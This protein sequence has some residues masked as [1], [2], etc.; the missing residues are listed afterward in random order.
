MLAGP[1]VG[2]NSSAR[3]NHLNPKGPVCILEKDSE[4]KREV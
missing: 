3:A 2:K 4:Q 1:L